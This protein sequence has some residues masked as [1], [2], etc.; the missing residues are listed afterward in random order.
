MPQKPKPADKNETFLLVQRIVAKRLKMNPERV[1]LTSHL[2]QDLGAD[3][4]DALEITMSIEEAFDIQIPEEA[5][6][7][8]RTIQQIID[9]VHESRKS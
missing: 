6:R 7:S 4:L 9:F 8:A 1:Q 3:S 5:A 2:Q